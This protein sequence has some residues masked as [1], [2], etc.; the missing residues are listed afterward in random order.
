MKLKPLIMGFAIPILCSTTFANAEDS[1][2]SLQDLL[3][4]A[5]ESDPWLV[6]SRQHESA[7]RQQATAAASLPDP[8]LTATLANLPTDSFRFAQE[9]M[10]QF[11]VGVSQ[12]FP[13][14]DTRRLKS[15]KLTAMGAQQPIQR[16]IRVATLRRQITSIWLE[17]SQANRAIELIEK[18]RPFYQ[19]LVK[20]TEAGYQAGTLTVS[21]QDVSR[22][23]LSLA[24]LDEKVLEYSQT[25]QEKIAR[26]SEWIPANLLTKKFDWQLT[27]ETAPANALLGHPEVLLIDEQI[28]A[29]RLERLT[30]QEATKPGWRLNTS[31]AY[32][33]EDFNGRDLP[34]FFSIGVSLDLPLFTRNRQ[35]QK[36]A[37]AA[38]EVSALESSRL[39]KIKQLQARRKTALSRIDQLEKTI[40]FYRGSL[41]SQFSTLSRS[42][43]DAYR[44]NEGDFANVMRANI[45]ELDA[46]LELLRLE[47]RLAEDYSEL[48]YLNT[49]K[50]VSQ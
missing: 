37:A 13:A 2:V 7:Y 35:D 28:Q 38:D 21:Q 42:E 48:E 16:A 36:I 17:L 6:K 25:R 41:L 33:D 19:Q 47:T 4:A 12:A 26:L 44:A 15:E 10:T 29:A 34:D 22:A 32:R 11:N 24:R 8:Q 30:Q 46:K 39:L 14:G 3:A 1:L 5:I 50:G 45:S 40:T 31:Y 9:P 18:D 20:T 27:N 49:S 23:Q 43:L